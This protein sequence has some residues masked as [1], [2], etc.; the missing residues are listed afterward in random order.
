[1]AASK[2]RVEETSVDP[3]LEGVPAPSPL[4]GSED[5]K[6]KMAVILE[7]I[8]GIRT[9]KSASDEMGVAVA[10]YYQLETRMLQA[11]VEAL[12]PQRRGPKVDHSE[13][14]K[15]LRTECK[16]LR[17]EVMRLKALYRTTQRAVGVKQAQPTT[18]RSRSG[19]T[20]RARKPRK[21][22]RGERLVS[23]LKAEVGSGNVAELAAG[24]P[25]VPA[26]ETSPV[27]SSS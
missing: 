20:V 8:A 1:M 19:K 9:I 21:T 12:E 7:A 11:M 15:Q 26:A 16:S 24:A 27:T 6:R 18:T 17:A 14:A 2:K 3:E 10:R 22:T 13:E 23:Q 25:P 5:A 4:K